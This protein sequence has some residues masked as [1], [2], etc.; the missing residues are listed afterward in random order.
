MA[1]YIIRKMA[2]LILMTLLISMVIYV[3]LDLTPGDPLSSILSPETGKN[4]T[5]AQ[6]EAFRE[7]NGLNGPIY[8]RYF[9]WLKRALH[10]NLG[11]SLTSGVPVTKLLSVRLEATMEL[12]GLSFIFSSIF[13]ILLGVIAAVRQNKASD[14]I[15]TTLGVLGISI[16]EFFLGI[17]MIL[18]FAVRLKWLP[19][20]GRTVTRAKTWWDTAKPYVL[21]AFVL[22]ASL[23]A[24]TIRYT[25][26]SM[27]DVLNKDYIKTALAKGVPKRLVY[28]RHALRNALQPIMNLLCF[29]LPMLLGGAVVIEDVF[30]W[31]GTGQSLLDAI[32]TKDYTV[33]M[34]ISLLVAMAFLVASFLVD[35][36]TALLDPRVRVD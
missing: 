25:R 16:P 8:V 33:V 24:N 9:N 35:I 30:L 21:P 12:V 13:G 31:P 28:I 18:L 5:E 7:A 22:G 11:Y 29:R 2:M 3:G 36:L 34:A 15:I 14:N 1:K 10:G 20:G 23:M 27:L 19:T 32:S 4:L 26:G 6:R 17:L